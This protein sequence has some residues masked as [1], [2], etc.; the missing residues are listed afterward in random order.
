MQRYKIIEMCL[1]GPA[2]RITFCKRRSVPLPL[3]LSCRQVR[4]V[5]KINLM[6]NLN[7]Y[8]SPVGFQ[9]E[10]PEISSRSLAAMSED[11][12]DSELVVTSEALV[13]SQLVAMAFEFHV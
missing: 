2:D 3:R 6:A 13:G 4:Q 12:V 5:T 10:R 11:L 1:D 9:P 8:E 7:P